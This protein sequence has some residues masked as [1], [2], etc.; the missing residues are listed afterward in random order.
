MSRQAA[1]QQVEGRIGR[2]LTACAERDVPD[3]LDL[4][5]SIAERLRRD[6]APAARSASSARPRRRLGWAPVVMGMAVALLAG[7]VAFAAGPTLGRFFQHRAFPSWQQVEQAGLAHAV[8]ASQTVAGTTVTVER[9][10]A[11][12]NQ[13]LIGYRVT[14]PPG[15]SV[16]MIK[17]RESLE[18]SGTP[19][20]ASAAAAVHPDL[21]GY[22]AGT[23]AFVRAFDAAPLRS[24]TGGPR[25]PQLRL[26]LDVALMDAAVARATGTPLADRLALAPT[27]PVGPFAFE[28]TVPTV[29]GCVLEPERAAVAAGVAIT[30]ERVEMAPT[31]TRLTLRFTPPGPDRGWAAAQVLR[32]PNWAS[33]PPGEP[34]PVRGLRLVDDDGQT[35]RWRSNHSFQPPPTASAGEWTLTLAELI[36]SRRTRGGQIEEERIAGPWALPFAVPQECTPAGAA[37]QRSPGTAVARAVPPST[38]SSGAP[39]TPV[40]PTAATAATTAAAAG[41]NSPAPVRS[42]AE[43]IVLVGPGA[44]PPLFRRAG[45]LAVDPQGHL[46]VVD[47]YSLSLHKLSPEGQPLAHWDPAGPAGA[48]PNMFEAAGGIV[49]DTEGNVYVADPYAHR[50]VKLAPN[51]EPLAAWGRNGVSPGEFRNPT[52]VALDRHGNIYVVE[53]RG[54]RIQKLSPTGVPLAQWGRGGSGPGEFRE[55]IAIA[56][57]RGDNVYVADWGNHRVQK[58]S[59][60]GQVLAVWDGRSAGGRGFEFPTDVAVDAQGNVYVANGGPGPYV[61]YQLSPAGD[62]LAVWSREGPTPGPPIGS[63]GLTIDGTGT[64]YVADSQSARV[65]KAAGT[66]R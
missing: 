59:P 55:P 35:M 62:L 16:N 65:L 52:G 45:S 41:S 9:L 25:V 36:A 24:E 53:H 13:V 46:Y 7:A 34:P 63:I 64:L 30:L 33:A 48:H 56:V 42:F 60:T 57:D 31:E 20:P 39:A 8:Q 43:W 29:A 4:W 10:Y 37:A 66:G 47:G 2:W 6:R 51:G 61:L 3:S 19:L 22:P 1:G 54:H 15:K 5:P 17:T 49:V 26:S 12:A 23:E 38:V 32:A 14:P 28:L 40:T 27:E 18:A 58:L 21:L 50:V 44:A 11:D